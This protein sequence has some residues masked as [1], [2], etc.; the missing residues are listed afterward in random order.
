MKFITGLL[1]KPWFLGSLVVI[2]VTL[3]IWNIPIEKRKYGL[4]QNSLVTDYTGLLPERVERVVIAKNRNELQRIVKEA[5]Q[6][7]QKIAVAGLQHSQG[8]HTYYK[9]G[10]VLDMRSFNQI[11]EIDERGK[12][13]V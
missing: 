1:K 9:N 6:K 12:P 2:I 13:F 11:L 8:G 10:V 5:N 3:I 4:S 7:G